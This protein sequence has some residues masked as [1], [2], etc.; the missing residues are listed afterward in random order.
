MDTIFTLFLL[1]A[2]LLGAHETVPANDIV[3]TAIAVIEGT[4]EPLLFPGEHR[5]WMKQA[6]H[7]ARF[8]MSPKGHNDKHLGGAC[9][10]WQV[11]S[12]MIPKSLGTC[13]DLR[14]SRALSLAAARTLLREAILRCGGVRS[15][16]GALFTRG[17]CGGAPM[18]VA[19]RCGSDC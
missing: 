4:P 6:Y 3:D 13:S 17:E 18:M 1:G 14:A 9:G 10:E 8:A 2:R 7:E 12:A 5:F 16:L 15:G 11:N 19:H